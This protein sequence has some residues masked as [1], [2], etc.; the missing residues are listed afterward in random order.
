M[1]YNKETAR[2]IYNALI[3]YGLTKA[4]ALGMMANI[5]AES[6][7]VSNNA[8][9]SGNKR[10]GLT[11]AEY[12]A[13]IDNGTRNFI[14]SIGYG[15]CQWTSSGR[16]KGLLDFAKSLG[17]SVGDES[18]QIAWL[19]HE[20][21]TSYKKVWSLLTTSNDISEC[22]KYVMT[23]FERPANQSEANQ[24][25]RANYG[26]T[27]E[28]E[29][30]TL[31]IEEKEIKPMNI[32]QEVRAYSNA[33]NGNEKL[34][35]NFTVDEFACED[36]SDPIFIAPSLVE[37]LQSIRTHFGKAVNINSGFRTAE[38]NKKKEV[39][40]AAYSQ[41]LYGKAADIRISGVSPKKIAKYAETL[42]PNTGGIGIYSNFVHIDVREVKSRWNG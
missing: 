28:N 15:L 7:F 23:K 27:L 17:K 8:Q 29:L 32:T 22:A 21:K 40:G 35:A 37:V 33:K 13:Q 20:L 25:V 9:N 1:N 39:G 11:D 2:R 31:L 26:L 12:T 41:H 38:Y 6:G 16:K 19:V 18:M 36:G 3:G 24:N 5:Y 42:L 30:R 34:S 14:D 4:G 10:L